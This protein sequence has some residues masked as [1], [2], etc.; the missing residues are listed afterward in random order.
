[1]KG[2][3]KF[4]CIRERRTDSEHRQGSEETQ[5]VMYRS[6]DNGGGF[7]KAKSR[8]IMYK[9]KAINL[10]FCLFYKIYNTI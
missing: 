1:M 6:N 8:D 5:V 4:A 3:E 2:Q 9:F 7:W 10:I